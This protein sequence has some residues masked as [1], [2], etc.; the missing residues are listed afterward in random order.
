MFPKL[1][2]LLQQV[3]DEAKEGTVHDITR[4]RFV[5]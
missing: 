1:A 2:D 4:Y 5:A 3:F